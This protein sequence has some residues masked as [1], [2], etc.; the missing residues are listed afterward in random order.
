VATRRAGVGYRHS[1]VWLRGSVVGEEKMCRNVV[2]HVVGD[3]CE[4]ESDIRNIA[5]CDPFDVLG[6]K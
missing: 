4:K 1:V 6:V 3:S 2:R 5:K